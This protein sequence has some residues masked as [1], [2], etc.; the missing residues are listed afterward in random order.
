MAIKQIVFILLN[1]IISS[2]LL[3]CTDY[4]S[5]PSTDEI[6]DK[7]YKNS[8]IVGAPPLFPHPSLPGYVAP[9][10]I[11]RSTV[12]LDLMP[13]TQS[14]RGRARIWFDMQDSGYPLFDY[15]GIIESLKLNGKIIPLE[16]IK[17]ITDPDNVSHLRVINVLLMPNVS[18]TLEIEFETPRNQWIQLS[19]DNLD[20]LFFYNDVD[21]VNGRGFLG[22]YL[23]SNLEFDQYELDLR[24][25]IK[26]S[27]KQ[28]QIFTN[29]S[30]ELMNQSSWRVKF[31]S[32]YNSSAAYFHLT[33]KTYN[34]QNKA[35]IRQGRRL[36]ITVYSPIKQLAEAGIQAVEKMLTKYESI[37]GTFPHQKIV[38]QIHQEKW[39]IEYSGAALTHLDALEHEFL[40]SWFGRYIFPA[41]GNDAW[42]DEALATWI[43]KGFPT[44]K[45]I[46]LPDHLMLASK[47]PYNRM[48]P[49]AAYL[50]GVGVLQKLDSLSAPSGLKPHIINLVNLAGGMVITNH[51]FQ[52]FLI[53]NIGE[54]ANSVFCQY[55][56]GQ[57]ADCDQAVKIPGT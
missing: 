9:I 33:T 11:K 57:E 42:L 29:G 21:A 52:K 36:P 32:Y 28:A 46:K 23:P 51:D 55:V 20:V 4:P 48:T 7:I 45:V 24:V 14:M 41:S 16:D 12:E 40:H 5:K 22:R 31:P 37:F 18:Y 56:Y 47:A 3:N 54:E 50:H 8:N 10:D 13:S 2:L 25:E 35:H 1:L 44:S 27:T 43:A 49:K 39:G 53:M 30:I 34:V 17:V 6:A 19:E 38:F 15:S 26:G